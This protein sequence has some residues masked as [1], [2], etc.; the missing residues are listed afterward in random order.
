MEEHW[1]GCCS[2]GGGLLRSQDRAP[3]KRGWT[4]LGARPARAGRDREDQGSAGLW[5]GQNLEHMLPLHS[6]L[7]SCCRTASWKR[8]HSLPTTTPFPPEPRIRA[9]TPDA[10]CNVSFPRSCRVPTRTKR[11]EEEYFCQ[12]PPG[13]PEQAGAEGGSCVPPT[14]HCSSYTHGTSWLPYKVLMNQGS[15]SVQPG[16]ALKLVC[17]V[18]LDLTRL[19]ERAA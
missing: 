14:Q 19:R 4:G 10:T 5:S 1:R 7:S 15:Q 13:I 11:H 8:L 12:E 16:L 18:Q 6:K 9:H 3:A 2:A 17:A